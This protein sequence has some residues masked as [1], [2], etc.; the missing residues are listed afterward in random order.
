MRI[1]CASAFA[2]TLLAISVAPAFADVR[3]PALLGSHMVLQREQPARVWGWAAPGESVSV[4][5]GRSSGRA[6]AGPDGR[7]Q[8]DLPAQPAGGPFRMAVAGRNTIELADVWIG[9]VWLASGQSNMEFPLARASGGAEAAQ[10]GCEGLRLFTVAKATSLTPKDDVSGAWS[11]CDATTASAFSAV[12]FYFGQELH[13]TLGVKVGLIHSSWGGTPAE[14]WTSREALSTDPTLRSL[15]A[16]FDAALSD[17]QAQASYAAKLEAWEKANYQQDAGNEGATNGWQ[18]QETGTTDWGRMDLPQR[19]EKAGLAIDGAVWF[20]RTFDLPAEWADKEL[21]L[22]LGPLDDFDVTYFAGEEVGRT[23]QETP[24]YWSVP[25]KYTVPARLAKAGRA[26]VAVRV[27]DHAGDGGFAGVSSQV[28]IAPADGSSAPI[29]LAG[30]WEYKVE[31][32]FTPLPV[33][34]STQPRFPSPDN[35]N[36]PTV[37]F[38]AMIAPLTSFSLRGAIWYQGESNAGAA[39]QYRTLFPA[40][41]RDWRRA[42]GH[43][44]F[45]FL[46]VQLANYQARADQPGES[47]WAELR[48]AQTM[49]LSQPNTGMAVAID[50]GVADDIHPTNKRDVGLRLA[51]WA[52]ADTYGKPV[53]KS[54]PLFESAVA[55]AGALRVRFRHGAGLTTADG[56]PP[57]RFALAGSDRRWH[58]AEARIDGETVLVSTSAVPHPIAVRYAWADNPEATLRNGEGLPASP[59]R[60]DDRPGLTS[61]GATITP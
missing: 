38:S 4:S 45:P 37:L 22:S 53:V 8:V 55:E 39:H 61:P 27:F 28:Q 59:F 54:G 50:I 1:R 17:P 33:D 19:W 14:A 49:T 57:R 12:A 21:T 11:T 6:T 7:W 5:V 60:S 35:P 13:R 16:D 43:G 25:R 29:P 58:W 2:V 42:W 48:E 56:Q 9:E 20:R 47:N 10:A 44:D 51:R 24:G 41:I 40:M 26:L 34:Y 31:R 18:K 23:G 46:F 36:S 52:L 30:P 15:V 32:A 3:L